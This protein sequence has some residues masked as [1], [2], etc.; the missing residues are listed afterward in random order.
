M[1]KKIKNVKSEVEPKTGV[2][3]KFI[4][5]K[6]TS[7]QVSKLVNTYAS[8]PSATSNGLNS[9]SFTPLFSASFEKEAYDVIKVLR[10]EEKRKGH[11]L[12]ATVKEYE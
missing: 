3:V 4:V 7:F 9:L 10:K 1:S 6:V 8:K 12:E 11:R 5:R 2:E